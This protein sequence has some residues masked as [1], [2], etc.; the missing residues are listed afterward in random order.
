M[1]YLHVNS[2]KESQTTIKRI[3]QTGFDP[4]HVN[5]YEESQTTIKKNNLNRVRSYEP[6]V[7]TKPHSV[8][9]E[10]QKRAMTL[11]AF[12]D[13]NFKLKTSNPSATHFQNLLKEKE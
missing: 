5:S 13:R 10:F 6:Q 2:Y 4:M 11:S 7:V 8:S 9:F 12:F 1:F 3:T